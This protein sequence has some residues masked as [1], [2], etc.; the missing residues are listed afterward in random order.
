MNFNNISEIVF[1]KTGATFKVLGVN[2]DSLK[3]TAD[4]GKMRY[5]SKF[6]I[7]SESIKGRVTLT[8]AS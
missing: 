5:I 6:Y 1:K 7:Y 3:V 8:F 2:K 4:D